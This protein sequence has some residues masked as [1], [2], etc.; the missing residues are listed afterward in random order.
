M[1]KPTAKAPSA[2]RRAPLIIDSAVGDWPAGLAERFP[3]GIHRVLLISPPDVGFAAFDVHLARSKRYWNY[4]PYGLLTMG[5]VL[6][7]SGVE[8]RILN[9]QDELLRF[10][11]R[12]DGDIDEAAYEDFI[13]RQLRKELDLAMPD[14]I[15]VSCMFSLT[16]GSLKG[17]I[18]R[19]K[20]LVDVPLA[21]G[22]AH[23]TNSCLDATTHDL[24]LNDIGDVDLVFLRESE[25]SMMRLVRLVNHATSNGTGEGAAILDTAGSIDIVPA[26]HLSPPRGLSDNGRI[27]TFEALIPGGTRTGTVLMNRGCR[28]ECTFC[29][30]RNLN[31]KGVRSRSIDSVVDEIKILKYDYGIDHIT[32][33]DDDFLFD[34]HR[35]VGL[36][37][38]LVREGIRITWDT[39]NGL[40]AA[41]VTTEIMHAAS[42]SGCI[43]VILG[44]ESGNEE[45]L[46]RIKKPGNVRHFLRAAEVLRAFPNINTRVFVMIGFPNE[47]F[48][49]IA[50]TFD[51]ADQMDM[52]WSIINVLQPLPNTPI[53]D[54]M[55]AA[56]LV[57]RAHSDFTRMSFSVGVQRKS[58]R[59]SDGK[60]MLAESFAGAFSGK[61][62]DAVPTPE[63]LDDLWAYM[64]Y[65]LNF[66]KLDRVVDRKKL[67]IQYKWISSVCTQLATSN[68]FAKHYR[69]I[70]YKRLKG[71]DNAEFLND[72]A[73]CMNR[74]P[75]WRNRF[76]EFGLRAR[77]P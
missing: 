17:I 5:R 15:G 21:V 69:N 16:H 56:N 75:Y 3:A 12:L 65:H 72:L 55:V 22:G 32:W 48:R 11:R 47:T 42:D 49:M 64:N 4:P 18:R 67:E 77:L 26:Y 76:E 34:R 36:F 30:V 40:I 35:A 24:F 68:A 14:L 63:E 46:R 20:A 28:A 74:M 37:N 44:M 23:V 27:S 2:G 39:T 1:L 8:V 57:D 59:R 52:D 10:A 70:L 54:E 13:S 38:S 7:T 51:V 50:D 43:G 60:D 29:S 71:E 73:D 61:N 45:T 41:S 62:M 66:K 6:E 53:Y 33:L 19:L 58:S 25:G 31:G 9:L